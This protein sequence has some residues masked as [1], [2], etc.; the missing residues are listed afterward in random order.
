M[1]SGNDGGGGGGGGRG[2]RS[3]ISDGTV[4]RGACVNVRRE[5]NTGGVSGDGGVDDL[6]DSSAP[7]PAGGATLLAGVGNMGGSGDRG[8]GDLGDSSTAGDC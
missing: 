8:A 6:D 2:R 3:R 7:G 4:V 1:G 5:C